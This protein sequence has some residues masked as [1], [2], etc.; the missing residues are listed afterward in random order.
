MGNQ[1]GTVFNQEAILRRR[2]QRIFQGFTLPGHIQNKAVVLQM[3][4]ARL[5]IRQAGNK[6]PARLA[7]QTMD[8]HFN[9]ERR[10]QFQGC[11]Q[12]QRDLCIVVS[13]R[14]SQP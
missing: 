6:D 13:L 3:G 9:M 5:A 11:S 4:G 8:R 7:I 1:I 14:Q 10:Q 2:A 12:L